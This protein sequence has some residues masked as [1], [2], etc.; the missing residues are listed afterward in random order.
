MGPNECE[1]AQTCATGLELGVLPMQQER[2][3]Q[4]EDE[5]QPH[6]SHDQQEPPL[7]VEGTFRQS[8]RQKVSTLT[9]MQSPVQPIQTPVLHIY[10]M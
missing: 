7:L 8:C 4:D 10:T 5:D 2:E 9:L 1:E 3:D 6:Q